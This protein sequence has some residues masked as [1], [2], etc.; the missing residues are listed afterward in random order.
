M[1]IL[2]PSFI[3]LFSASLITVLHLLRPRFS[4][5]WLVA[6]LGAFLSW[7]SMLFLRLRLPTNMVFLE[8]ETGNLYLNSPS[9]AIDYSSW[10]YA[11]AIA[12]LI[13]SIVLSSPI[14]LTT[15]SEIIN[16]AG[17]LA[18]VAIS[19]FSILASNLVALLIGWAAIDI[20]ELLVLLRNN[21]GSS[22]NQRIIIGFTSRIGGL[23][24][25]FLA[26]V[27][28]S[29][30]LGFQTGF[31]SLS[32]IAGFPILLGIGL[33]LGLY[34]IHLTYPENSTI[35]RSQGN[36]F[37]FIPAVSSLVLLTR[38]PKQTFGFEYLAI[39]K[40][41]TFIAACYGLIRFFS[42]KR[43]LDSRSF[44]VMVL[45]SFAI[46]ST[47]NGEPFS[48]TTWGVGMIL[49]GGALFLHDSQTKFIKVLLMFG[50]FLFTGIPFTPN[51]SGLSG[52]VGA[53]NII[54]EI[55]SLILFLIL[56]GGLAKRIMNKPALPEGQERIVYLTFPLS[57]LLLILSY[58]II[59]I[60][61]WPGS[62]SMGAWRAVIIGAGIFIL[63]L[64]VYIK[65]S[66]RLK[67]YQSNTRTILQRNPIIYKNGTKLLKFTW[68]YSIINGGINILAKAVNWFTFLLEGD[69]GLLWGMVFLVLLVMIIS[70]GK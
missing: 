56:L 26:I 20:I 59:G 51:A 37:R 57:I 52:L 15:K 68:V 4:A 5:N 36:L 61:G 8:W 29:R 28:G 23:M 34:P 38:I 14:N 17:N 53:E 32:P 48:S 6:V 16:I 69:S 64:L 50:I 63:V 42:E 45:S 46:L 24:L 41:L 40:V 70:G 54:D 7:L 39:I 19:Y 43:E 9:L 21:P 31:E 60:F 25:I 1:L 27:L 11:F 67:D 47:I 65:Y 13:L 30:A 22:N 58:I 49:L 55:F 62:L 12:T 44:W 3:L 66:S 35:R 33:R 18:F 10:P 2:L